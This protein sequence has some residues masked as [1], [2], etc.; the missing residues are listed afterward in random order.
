VPM[1]TAITTSAPRDRA[2]STGRLRTTPPSTSNRPSMVTG[3][4]TAGTA[5]LARIAS[6]RLPLPM[7]T[8]SAVAR[9][10]AM[11]RKRMGSASKSCTVCKR[12]RLRRTPSSPTPAMAPLGSE[13]PPRPMPIS[14]PTRLVSASALRRS[15]TSCRSKSRISAAVLDDAISRS[16]SATDSPLAYAAPM[17]EPALVPTMMSTGT[18]NSSRTRS[19]PRCAPPRAPPPDSTRPTLGR[20]LAAES[21]VWPET[22]AGSTN[23]RLTSSGAACV[24]REPSAYRADGSCMASGS[25]KV[26]MG[27]ASS[28][29]AVPPPGAL[30]NGG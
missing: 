18:R 22:A 25:L 10:V 12:V 23:A 30:A 20:G 1:F 4:T 19:T 17:I 21:A 16:M 28:V 2:T 3:F 6:A 26:R 8:I 27:L 29:P 5:M 15:G 7:T 13:K 24:R 11:A 9:S 14:G